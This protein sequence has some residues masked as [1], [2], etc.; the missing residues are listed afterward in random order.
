MPDGEERKLG[1]QTRLDTWV[2]LAVNYVDC[3]LRVL[4]APAVLKENR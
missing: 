2:V 3:V 4:W 1:E